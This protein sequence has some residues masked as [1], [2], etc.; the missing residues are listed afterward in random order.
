MTKVVKTGVKMTIKLLL[1]VGITFFSCREI[2]KNN[3]QNI[4]AAQSSNSSTKDTTFTFQDKIFSIYQ[5]SKGH[6]WIGSREDGLCKYDGENYTYYTT[7]D[8][9]ASNTVADI[10]EDA[11]G[12]IWFEGGESITK[13][14]GRQ[15]Q[16]FP[17]KDIPTVA[18][19]K[20][21]I[22]LSAN[23]LWFKHI[24]KVGAG[25]R[26]VY[27]FDGQSLSFISFEP[28]ALNLTNEHSHFWIS[29][30]SKVQ[31]NQ[32]WF[33]TLDQGVIGFNGE[34]LEKI[35][36][37]TMGYDGENEFVHI[38]SLLLGT[39]NNL[40]I[41][42]N[43][44]GILLKQD[45]TI[46]NFSREQGKLMSFDNFVLQNRQSNGLQAIFAI[47]EDNDGNIWFGE[48]TTGAWKYDG[49]TLTN[50][51]NIYDGL[52]KKAIIWDIYNDKTGK[53]WFILSS[54]A[55][56]TFNEQS[57]KRFEGFR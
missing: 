32:V 53:L 12:H 43:G 28:P 8:G 35:D 29:S 50:Y 14:D 52:T 46:K 11:Q 23:N 13:F 16:V 41:G 56:F 31:N 34:K 18:I 51:S 9:L 42:N 45:N 3:T 55:V 44:V 7:N 47:E 36:D 20:A 54:G 22:Q 21:S 2:N 19:G 49:T 17:K 15:F 25:D 10:Q 37:Q 26:G 33:G 57:F 27:R 38:R 1:F 4:E 39:K 24:V 48:T 40:W 5:D 6:Y 30:I